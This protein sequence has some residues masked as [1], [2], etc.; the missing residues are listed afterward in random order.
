MEGNLQ[1]LRSQGTEIVALRTEC[2]VMT[3]VLCITKSAFRA[4]AG[5]LFLPGTCKGCPHLGG[6]S[7]QPGEGNLLK[8]SMFLWTLD[9][10]EPQ[11]HQSEIRVPQCILFLSLLTRALHSCSSALQ[12]HA[13]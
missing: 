3:G 6:S 5:T 10:R 2:A 11:K 13:L 12:F 8:A 7:R 1:F 9:K 4:L